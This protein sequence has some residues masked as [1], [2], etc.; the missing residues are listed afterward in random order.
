MTPKKLTKKR[1][2]LACP[3]PDRMN[4]E[5]DQKD[6]EKR[7]MV[8]WYKTLV[9]PHLEYCSSAKDKELLEKLHHRFKELKRQRL[10]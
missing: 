8:N 5:Y 1:Q 7:I 10:S 4:L 3:L 9:R 6:K 2:P